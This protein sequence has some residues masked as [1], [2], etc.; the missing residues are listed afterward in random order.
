[1]AKQNPLESPEK[2]IVKKQTNKQT[3]EF[4]KKQIL[5]FIFW[6]KKNADWVLLQN[7]KFG[8]IGEELGQ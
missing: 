7:H 8:L 2:Q 6:E 3:N 4:S 1:M 5:F